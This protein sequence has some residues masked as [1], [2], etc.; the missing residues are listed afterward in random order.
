MPRFIPV[1]KLAVAPV[2]EP[3]APILIVSPPAPWVAASAQ[4]TFSLL[5]A[6]AAGA[7]VAAAGALVAAPPAAG[8]VVAAA[9][10]PVEAAGA[11]EQAAA[12]KARML[13]AMPARRESDGRAN[14]MVSVGVR[15]TG[16]P[17]LSGYRGA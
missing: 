11:W 1:P 4:E 10:P 8:A 7:L 15:R 13:M 9:E 14:E 5:D 12:S 6:A 16:L 3:S 2:S 17:F